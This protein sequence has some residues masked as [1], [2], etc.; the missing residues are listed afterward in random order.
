M[1]GNKR[2]NELHSY[3]MEYL[4]STLNQP[5]LSCANLQLFA[6]AI[7]GKGA[8][9]HSCWG[10]I[11]GTGSFPGQ[12]KTNVYYMTVT[13]KFIPLNSSQLQHPV[14]KLPTNM[15]LSKVKVMTVLCS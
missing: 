3:E 14:G 11:D 10:F 4:L 2:S 13:K 12:E 1:Y 7:L 5:W 9:L 15:D 6:N 8:G